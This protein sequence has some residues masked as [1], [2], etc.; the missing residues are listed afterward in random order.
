VPDALISVAQARA[1][2]EAA[3]EPLA[4]ERV[5]V[6]EAYGRA[7]GEDVHAAG[8]V[9]AFVNS[10]MDGFAVTGGPAGRDLR[11]IGEARAG[12]P[13]PGAIAPDEAVRISTGAAVP[14]GAT[15][16]IPIESAS[17][18]AP[19]RVHL[20]AAAAPGLYLRGAGEDMRAGDLVIARGRR[21]GAAE[22]GVAVTAGRA[23]LRCARRPRVAIV[24][25]GDE[26]RPPGAP[27]GPGEIH[28]ANAVTLHALT[29]NAGAEPAVA[30]DSPDEREQTVA[31]LSR[32]LAASDVL[33]VS[34][35]VS[36]GPHDHVK[37]ALQALGVQERFWRV[38][39]RPGKPTWF[40]VRDRTLVFGL[41][42]N[43]VSAMV[44]FV[45]FVAPALALLQGVTPE[46]QRLTATLGETYQAPA[47]RDEAVRV[48]LRATDEGLRA[49]PTG[50]QD[51]HRL[52]SMLGADALMIVPAGHTASAG[53]RVQVEPI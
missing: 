37:A 16:I 41:P 43:P 18:T 28:N 42:G 51:S 6:A 32:A 14:D 35:G 5:A 13:F 40:G 30:E 8:D 19:G 36:V 9:P 53:A 1:I 39:L 26:L 25:T 50:P 48:A 2:I 4:V 38:A 11:I 52:T 12:A 44:T 46:R 7:L 34:G 3:V 29:L 31:A 33:V 17:E 45:L 47:D 24:T 15:A 20:Q 10:A 21:L 49:L 27:L 22:L 23:E